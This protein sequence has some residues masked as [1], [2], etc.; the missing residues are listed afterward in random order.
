MGLFCVYASGLHRMET[1]LTLKVLHLQK[2]MF[3]VRQV[4]FVCFFYKKP[5]EVKVWMLMKPDFALD[6]K[7]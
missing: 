5:K 1:I 3:F 6:T 4:K 7:L 2:F